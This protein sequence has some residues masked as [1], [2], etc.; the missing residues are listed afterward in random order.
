VVDGTGGP[1]G[2]SAR[3]PGSAGGSI[4]LTV[5]HYRTGRLAAHDGTPRLPARAARSRI[6]C[7]VPSDPP[8]PRDPSG[9][10]ALVIDTDLTAR[11]AAHRTLGSAPREQLEWLASR[12][13]LRR[14]GASEQIG[15]KGQHIDSLYVVLEGRMCIRVDRGGGPRTVMEWSAGDVAG[16]LPYSRLIASPGWTTAADPVEV[17]EVPGEHFREMAA[18]CHELTAI[19]V[20]VML[21]RA[22]RF[23]SSD[24]HDEKM[25]SLGRLAAGLAHE[26]NNPASALARSASELSSRLF[27]TE[28]TALALGS[29]GLSAN[30]LAA[31][32]SARELCDEPRARAGLSPLERADREEA[33][34]DWLARRGLRAEIA[35]DLVETP[36]SVESLDRLAAVLGGEVLAFA[37][38]SIGA[39]HRTRLLAFEVETA[40]RRIHALVAAIRGFTYMDQSGVPSPVDI[41]QGLSDTKTVLGAKARGKS[42][43]VTVRADDDLPSIEGFGGELNQVWANLIDNAIDAAPVSGRVEVTAN[44]EGD[45]VVVRVVDDGPGVPPD[46]LRRIFEPFFTTKPVGEG[47]GL[48]LDIARR[49]VRQHNGQIEVDSRPGRTEFR[50]I[51]PGT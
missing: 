36:L 39:S 3:G 42:V 40:A 29:M 6:R 1:D 11:L 48:G 45:S 5:A 38:R 24:L 13:A 43:T 17:L 47:T 44:R 9:G 14:F 50:V 37:L 41:G 8:M 18:R 4:V 21:D 22:R 10:S 23:T 26:L 2:D 28:A 49:L 46:R 34:A 33:V 12:G 32:G 31:V 16:L 35:E 7:P 15:S 51:L 19:L 30:Q 25:L 27:E 20:H